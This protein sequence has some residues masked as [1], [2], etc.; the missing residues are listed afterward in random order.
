MNALQ[1]NS[2]CD[3]PVWLLPTRIRSAV[4]EAIAVTQAP[5]ALVVSSALAA[6]SLSVQAK[7][8]VKRLNGL[9]SPC[10][11]YLITFAESGERKTTVDQLFFSPFRTFEAEVAKRHVKVFSEEGGSQVAEDESTVEKV[12]ILYSDVTPAAFLAGL[13]VNSSS[14]GLCDDEAG[15]IFSGRLIDDLGLLNKLWNGSDIS[16]DRRH[17]TLSI[18]SPR[19]TISWMVQPQVFRR[20]MDR[21]GEDARGIGFLARCLLSYPV[22]TQGT[23]FLRNQPDFVAIPVFGNRVMELLN[24]QVNFFGSNSSELVGRVE[25]SF[26]NPAQASWESIF[27]NVEYSIQPGGAFCEAR[28]YASKVAENIARLAGVFHAF[29]G[30]EGTKI[31]DATLYSASEVVLWY[32]REFIRLFSPPS[33]H[34]VI[35]EY[36]R[37]LDAWL[38][39]FCKT[40]GLSYIHRNDLLQLGPNKLRSRDI[41]NIA[42]QR[43]AETNRVMCRTVFPPVDGRKYLKGTHV[44]ELN[45]AYYGQIAR[46]NQPF[47]F[48]PL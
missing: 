18:K 45:D 2:G 1:R 40:T 31:S 36:A 8:T 22:S 35:Y 39:D 33:P 6:A 21:K 15:R 42:V 25:L 28:D 11:L 16:V 19:C 17:E 26:S 46:G 4:E 30:H 13:N 32:A 47:G 9:I 14:A 24:E 48:T 23:R 44:L 7:F 20:F 10:S 5:P 38:I 29:E 43:L 27:N 3:F 37:L 41:L 34:D 12:R